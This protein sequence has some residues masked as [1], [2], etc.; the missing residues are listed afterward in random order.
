[1]AQM[2]KNKHYFLDQ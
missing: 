2:A 1:M